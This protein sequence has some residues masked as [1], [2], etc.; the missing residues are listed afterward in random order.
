MK[1]AGRI[2]VLALMLTVIGCDHV[3]K[4]IASEQLSGT[5]GRSYLNDVVR[6]EYAENSGAFLSWGA[7]LPGLL[8]VGAGIGLIA[9]ATIAIKGQW[10]GLSLIGASLVVAGGLSNL[11]DRIARGVVI[12][13][14]TVGWGALRTGVFNI[15]DVALVIG[16]A[17]IVMR[18]H[19]PR[20][21]STSDRT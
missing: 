3:T 12:D 11:V 1:T 5:A 9:I 16:V 14:V 15:A 20:I 8:I 19:R 6:F 7:G 18:G 10:R 21:T 13:F 2:F 17:M 4:R